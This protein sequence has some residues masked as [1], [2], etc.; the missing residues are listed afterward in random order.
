MTATGI[1]AASA[2]GRRRW[3]GP[4]P[5]RADRC[6]RAACRRRR[7]LHRLWRPARS[8]PTPARCAARGPARRRARDRSRRRS[9]SRRA[10]TAEWSTRS[11]R[12]ASARSRCA[13][14]RDV[15]RASPA[16]LG[17]GDQRRRDARPRRPAEHE[18]PDAGVEHQREIDAGRQ[19]GSA[20]VSL[21]HMR[22][23]AIRGEK[24]ASAPRRCASTTRVGCRH[25]RPAL[26][27]EV[28]IAFGGHLAAAERARSGG[29]RSPSPRGSRC[30][31]R[32][33]PRTSSTS[34]GS[35]PSRAGRAEADVD[36][37]AAQDVAAQDAARQR[38]CRRRPAERQPSRL[39]LAEAA[40]SRGPSGR[41][42][43][44]RS[45]RSKP[46]F[47]VAGV[48]RPGWR[49]RAASAAAPVPTSIGKRLRRARRAPR[50]ATSAPSPGHAAAHR[51]AREGDRKRIEEG[52]ESCRRSRPPAPTRRPA[53]PS[54]A[55]SGRRAHAH[56]SFSS[57]FFFMRF[58]SASNPSLLMILLNSA[59]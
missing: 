5:A 16:G 9:R 2:P 4:C 42:R 23:A 48:V 57:S 33:A 39:T 32:G 12:S 8:G 47:S 7:R 37:V 18:R 24:S 17:L 59:R 56:S 45:S 13:A 55:S 49:R 43:V 28:R 52:A 3:S 6:R 10:R 15:S 41:R 25:Q 46:A 30:R 14:C 31:R 54:A 51:R 35:T 44:R 1:C 53:A 22:R 27:E 38:R 19:R 36:G 50:A 26:P 11:R 20:S 40:R 29:P 21:Q 34:S 58:R